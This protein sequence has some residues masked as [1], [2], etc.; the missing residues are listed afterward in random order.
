MSLENIVHITQFHVNSIIYLKG[1]VGLPFEDFSDPEHVFLWEVSVHPR[2]L[3]VSTSRSSS[4]HK[5][6]HILV[7]FE[8]ASRVTLETRTFEQNQQSIHPADF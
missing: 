2:F 4:R 5:A 1:V 7:T 8:G 3:G 6:Y